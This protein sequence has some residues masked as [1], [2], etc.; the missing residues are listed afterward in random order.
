ML[1]ESSR[2]V[3]SA[4]KR[5]RADLSCSDYKGVSARTKSDRNEKEKATRQASLRTPLSL[6]QGGLET[7]VSQLTVEGEGQGQHSFAY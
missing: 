1:C 2:S 7:L 6:F 5:S 4:A 3:Q